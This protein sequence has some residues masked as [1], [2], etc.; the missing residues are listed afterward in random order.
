MKSIFVALGTVALFSGCAYQG[1][2][3]STSAGYEVRPDR[4]SKGKAYVYVTQDVATLEKT[5]KPGFICSAHSYP[6]EAGTA[7]KSSIIKTMEAAYKDVIPV[8]SVGAAGKDG[9][10]YSFSLDEFTPRLRFAQGFWTGTADATVE[11]AFKTAAIEPSGKDM[12]R[13]TVRGFGQDSQEGTC[14]VG[15]QA[16]TTAAEKAIRVALENFVGKVINPAAP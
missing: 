3:A 7:L 16:L 12:A 4:V 1:H 11:I 8:T 6:L 9:P 14:D 5:V 15:A 10:L 2:V 13:T